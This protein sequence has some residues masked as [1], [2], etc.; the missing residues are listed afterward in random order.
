MANVTFSL[1]TKKD[2]RKKQIMVRFTHA[3]INQRAKSG[4]FIE[5]T[6]WDDVLQ[7]VAIPKPRLFTDEIIAV[8]KELR[9][10]DAQLRALR[11]RIEDAFTNAP[12]APQLN[13]EWL[14]QII[15]G[16]AYKPL[17]FENMSFF[18]AWDTFINTKKV[19][20]ARKKMYFVVRNMLY[21]YEC[22]RRMTDER[23]TLSLNDFPTLLLADFE[24]FLWNEEKYAKLYP[25]IYRDV[26]I[27]DTTGGVRRGQNTISCRLKVFRTFFYW[28]I[29][30]N[31]ATSS[32][33]KK[34]KIKPEVYGR[35]IYINKEERDMLYHHKMSK[36]YLELAR[37]MFILQ[38]CIGCRVSDL[39]S[40]TRKNVIDNAIEYIAEKTS[41]DRSD[42]IR[43]PLNSI[44]KEIITRY[45]D[46]KRDS[47]LPFLSD[48]A[49]NRYIKKCF[50]E[51]G[52]TRMV[53]I[54]DSKTGKNKQVR[55][56]DYV[57]SHM[58]R[59]T[60]IG[61]LYK[62][63]QDPNLI[64]ALSGHKEN[65][66]AFLHYRDIDEDLKRKTVRLLE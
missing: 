29:D 18:E 65:S 25:D 43:V 20:D 60:F 50:E 21:R 34:Y 8:I 64:G 39:L 55:I 49:Y 31:L 19:S 36:P 54:P 61:I 10:I 16:E 41:D 28:A 52:I 37:D 38:A 62:Q 51:A 56:C 7:A 30:N 2:G 23:F 40:L 5:E 11:T 53:T 17:S 22:V 48:Q 26:R 4:L 14:K 42:V 44:A 24:S 12:S 27:N 9:E 57:A 59:K 15:S 1:S 66:D 33:F 32:P 35:P 63:V 13:K 45:K 58:A 3:K 47:L 46:K 6:Y